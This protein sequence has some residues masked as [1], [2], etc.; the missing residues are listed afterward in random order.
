MDQSP[1]SEANRFAASQ[2]IPRISRDPKVHYRT[3][4]RPPPVHILSQLDPVHIPPHP[5]SCR[6]ILKLSTHLRLGFP[7]GLFPLGLPHPQ[8]KPCMLLLC[9]PI[10]ATCLA[11]RIIL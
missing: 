3:H 10:R 9:H 4:K 6:S 11:Q 2:E 8:K 1:S 5:N 7:S